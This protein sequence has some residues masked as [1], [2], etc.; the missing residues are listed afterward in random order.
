MDERITA[1][2]DGA[3]TS[4]ISVVGPTA[5][6]KSELAVALVRLL[7]N[8]G[9]QA[10]IVNAD[11][12]QM[13]RGMDVGTAKPTARQQAAA[14][15]H[16]IDVIDPEEP[17]SVARYQSMARSCI[18]SLRRRGVRPVLVG[19]SGLYARAALDDIRFPGTDPRVRGE[20]ERRARREGATALFAELNARDPKAATRMD[21]RNV[22]RTIRA[23]EVIEITGRPYSATLPRYQYVMPAVQ[24]GLD[25]PRE[26]LDR[27]IDLRTRAMREAGLVDEVRRLRPRLGPTAA[28]AL[29]YQ[30]II[31]YLDGRASLDEAFALI[32]RATRR[33]ARKQMGWFGRDPRI[34]WIDALAPDAPDRALAIVLQADAGPW[35]RAG[36]DKDGDRGGDGSGA[37]VSGDDD[38]ACGRCT[39]HHLGDVTSE[40]AGSGL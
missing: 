16:L 10:E 39:R 5:S 32:A 22:R 11:A 14:V 8:R 13:Y 37:G 4:V 17:M 20:L 18:A 15:H 33:L 12:Y 31:D 6:G 24:I 28:R 40:P 36:K 25:L 34:H 2:H 9:E 29:G 19:G 26:E 27:R 38:A 3:G 7:E 21:P 35:D 1:R 30:Q 23:L